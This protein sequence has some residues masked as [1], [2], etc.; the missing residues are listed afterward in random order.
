LNLKL[1]CFISS[2]KVTVAG[3]ISVTSLRSQC[4]ERSSSTVLQLRV[5]CY[6]NLST[7]ADHR[8]RHDPC[9][10]GKGVCLAL[11]GGLLA[12]EGD[13]WT[14]LVQQT[15]S[16]RHFECREL[17]LALW[18]ILSKCVIVFRM[19]SNSSNSSFS[20]KFSACVSVAFLAGNISWSVD[21]NYSC[22][23]YSFVDCRKRSCEFTYQI[24]SNAE[25]VHS[26]NNSR[27]YLQSGTKI[28]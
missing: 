28:T 5:I 11:C 22:Q 10:Y 3:I 2:V 6:N 14:E 26:S 17:A 12:M 20:T 13:N 19:R 21:S 9:T 1:I 25:Y 8:P 23:L 16:I 24:N 18:G 27:L 4:A 7:T 15:E